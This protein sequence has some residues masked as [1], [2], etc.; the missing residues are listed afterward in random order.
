[1]LIFRENN[2]E[3]LDVHEPMDYVDVL[4]DVDNRSIERE[5]FAI[6]GPDA[7][8]SD[9]KKII[10]TFSERNRPK[11]VRCQVRNVE[12]WVDLPG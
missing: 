2:F 3:N 1:M 5:F 6:F 9:L 11:R 10:E 7:N 8:I 12:F 4:D